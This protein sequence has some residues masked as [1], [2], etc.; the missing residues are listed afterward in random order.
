MMAWLP[1][2]QMTVNVIDV[3]RHLPSSSRSAQW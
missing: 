3:I 1:S 2:A